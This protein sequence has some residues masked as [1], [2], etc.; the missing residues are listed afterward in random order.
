LVFQKKYNGSQGSKIIV[1]GKIYFR[2]WFCINAV[3]HQSNVVIFTI[4]LKKQ[5]KNKKPYARKENPIS[6]CRIPIAQTVALH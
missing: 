1:L 2:N 6:I 5:N 3:L 4:H